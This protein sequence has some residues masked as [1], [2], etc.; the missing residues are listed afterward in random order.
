MKAIKAF[1]D[2]N[3]EPEHQ[4]GGQDYHNKLMRCS[5]DVQSV[6]VKGVNHFSLLNFLISYMLNRNSYLLVVDYFS[7]YLE[8]VKLK[9]TTLSS[10]IEKLKSIFSHHGIPETI[11]SDN[12]PQFYLEVSQKLHITSSPHFP[13]SNGLAERSVQTMKRVQR[14]LPSNTML[15]NNS[16]FLVQLTYHWQN[17]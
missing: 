12:G 7:R 10:I 11:V 15:S 1:K 6:L 5:R 13:Q 14:C 2:V 9:S 8:V 3:H 16:T 4:S 17:Y